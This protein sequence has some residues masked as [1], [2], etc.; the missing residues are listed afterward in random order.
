MSPIVGL[1]MTAPILDRAAPE[2]HPT[3]GP[4]PAQQR[5]DMHFR[6]PGPKKVSV[7]AWRLFTRAHPGAQTRRSNHGDSRLRS[8]DHGERQRLHR[9][10]GEAAA[11]RGAR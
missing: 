9:A 8:R 11:E 3:E 5:N 1:F 4:N 6:G 2:I 7:V 10:R